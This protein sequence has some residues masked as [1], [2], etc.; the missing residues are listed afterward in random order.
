MDVNK[1]LYLQK[2]DE[3][4]LETIVSIIYLFSLNQI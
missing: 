1:P 4:S 3:V 2:L